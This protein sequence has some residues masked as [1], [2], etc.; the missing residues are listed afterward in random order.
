MEHRTR[1]GASSLAP[2]IDALVTADHVRAAQ[3]RW[4]APRATILGT[5]LVA[6][7]AAG[8]WAVTPE[9]PSGAASAVP[10]VLGRV[11]EE[12]RAVADAVRQTLALPSDADAN[13]VPPSGQVPQLHRMLLDRLAE[14]GALPTARPET[15]V[16]S[17]ADWRK[18][19]WPK[20]GLAVVRDGRSILAGV[21]VNDRGRAVRMAGLYR[22][23]DDGQWRGWWL[24]HP[25]F[26]PGAIALGSDMIQPERA[27][28]SLGAL[29]GPTL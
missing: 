12:T 4:L 17:A 21:I 10:P 7:A 15:V 6:T 8:L 19:G 1:A 9:W 5:L 16:M 2:D 18:G 28:A 29:L 27:A 3:V 25:A 11:R 24:L 23:G 22:R 14:A 20:N 26:P 13:Q